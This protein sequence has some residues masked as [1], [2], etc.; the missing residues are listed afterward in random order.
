MKVFKVSVAKVNYD[1]FDSCVVVAE[2][3]EAVRAMFKQVDNPESWAGSRELCLPGEDPQDAAVWFYN[4]QGEITI[5]EVDLTQTA[6]IC[7]SFNAG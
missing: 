2:S 3:A 7:A 6:L 4:S 5:E 1:Q